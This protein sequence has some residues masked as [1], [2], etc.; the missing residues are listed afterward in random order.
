M[1][2]SD[3]Y[4]LNEDETTLKCISPSHSLS[5]SFSRSRLNFFSTKSYFTIVRLSLAYKYSVGGCENSVSSRIYLVLEL[6]RLFDF[7]GDSFEGIS[8]SF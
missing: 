7:R 5:L 1:S 6:A 4:K 2:S 8:T 3:K